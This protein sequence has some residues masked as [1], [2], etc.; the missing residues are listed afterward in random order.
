[1]HRNRGRN[2]GGRPRSERETPRPAATPRAAAGGATGAIESRRGIPKEL[3]HGSG[4][5]WIFYE[6][7]MI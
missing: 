4:F 5:A 2:R 1:M 3:R 7:N 6:K